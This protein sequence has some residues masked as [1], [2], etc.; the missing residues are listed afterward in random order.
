MGR[1]LLHCLI[2]SFCWIRKYPGHTSVSRFWRAFDKLDCSFIHKCLENYNFPQFIRQWIKILYT[3]IVSCVTKNGWHSN[4]FRLSRGVRQGCLLSPY[5]FILCAEFL[6]TYIRH[7]NKILGVKIGLKKFKI[8]QYADDAHIFS[9]F[10]EESVKEIIKTFSN[11]SRVSGLEINNNKKTEVMRIGS[12]KNSDCTIITKL[13]LKWT[14]EPTKIL[15][16]TLTQDITRIVETNIKPLTEK[17][18]NYIQIWCQRKLT[19][20]GKV[21]VIK[22][23]LETQLVYRLSTLPSPSSEMLKALDKILYN[24]LWDN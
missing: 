21:T 18:K 11:F 3:D 20:F 7:N 15:G 6:T 22:S 1:I 10:T 5:L 19:L 12:I 9:H 4:Y 17:N 2:Y 14:L 23:L 8:K 24:F 16:I 13:A